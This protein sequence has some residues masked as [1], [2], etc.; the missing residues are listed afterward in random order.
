MITFL[1]IHNSRNI[2]II[3][4]TGEILYSNHSFSSSFAIRLPINIES[5]FPDSLR[6]IDSSGYEEPI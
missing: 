2:F 3:D 5:L 1:Y 4:K 6:M